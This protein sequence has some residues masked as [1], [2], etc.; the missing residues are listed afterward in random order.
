MKRLRLVG[1]SLDLL[2]Y[3]VQFLLFYLLEREAEQRG[4]IGLIEGPRAVIRNERVLLHRASSCFRRSNAFLRP[5]T[6][7]DRTV[8]LLMFSSAPISASLMRS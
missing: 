3:H 8:L 7:V 4:L 2:V 6:M 1:R 5:R